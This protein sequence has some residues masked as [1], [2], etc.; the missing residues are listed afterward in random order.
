MDYGEANVTAK[1]KTN[2]PETRAR[3][4]LK[5]ML[6]TFKRSPEHSIFIIMLNFKPLVRKTNTRWLLRALR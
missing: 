3:G 4:T 6:E 5:G 2:N 1:K